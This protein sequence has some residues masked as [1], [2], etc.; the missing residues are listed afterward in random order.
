MPYAYMCVFELFYLLVIQRAL[1]I[2][3]PSGKYHY[4]DGVANAATLELFLCSS[5]FKQ[6]EEAGYCT[7][8]SGQNTT[9]MY[10]KRNAE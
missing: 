9:K 6:K 10:R 3:H 7:S 5:T 8:C 4:L 2:F 1:F